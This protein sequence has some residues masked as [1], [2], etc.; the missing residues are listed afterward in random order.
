[1]EPE[2]VS[3]SITPRETPKRRMKETLFTRHLSTVVPMMVSNDRKTT[4]LA[5]HTSAVNQAVNRQEVNVVL[6]DRPPL[7]NNSEKDLTK[8]ERTTLAHVFLAN[9]AV[10]VPQIDTSLYVTHSS[11]PL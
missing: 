11:R 5:I 3:N 8:K 4:L 2:N 1:M 10:D 9:V 7:I 6:A